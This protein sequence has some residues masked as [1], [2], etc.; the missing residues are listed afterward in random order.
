MCMPN[1]KKMIYI[2]ILTVEHAHKSL[3]TGDKSK[4]ILP[5]VRR[6][7]NITCFNSA[8]WPEIIP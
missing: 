8:C 4:A 1:L 2:Y 5:I 6:Y 3:R 7:N